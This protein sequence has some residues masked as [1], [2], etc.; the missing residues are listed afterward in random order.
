MT[1][2]VE[3]TGVS[4]AWSAAWGA[5]EGFSDLAMCTSRVKRSQ[6]TCKGMDRG[7]PLARAQR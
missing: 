4:A 1:Q 7:G 6:A 2:N 5:Q 3:C